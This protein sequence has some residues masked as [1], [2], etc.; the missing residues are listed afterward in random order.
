MELVLAF[1]FVNMHRLVNIIKD[2]RALTPGMRKR[3]II[4][5][6]NDET[7]L[8]L[9]IEEIGPGLIADDPKV[10]PLRLDV[11]AE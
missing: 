1:D 10:Y 6:A 8:R 4:G 11:L 5:E 7:L 9:R 3:G 2:L